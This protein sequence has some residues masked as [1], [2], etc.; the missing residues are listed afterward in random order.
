[1]KTTDSKQDEK[2]KE[3]P[4]FGWATSLFVGHSPLREASAAR[5]AACTSSW[6]RPQRLFTRSLL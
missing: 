1:M 6:P 4:S 5:P 2:A 3:R